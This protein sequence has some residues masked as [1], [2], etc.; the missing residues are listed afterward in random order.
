MGKQP[1]RRRWMAPI[2]VLALL[3][4]AVFAGFYLLDWLIERPGRNPAALYGD[5]QPETISDATGGM[6]GMM[7]AVLGIVI[8]VVSIIVQLSAERY[9]GVAQMFMR[10]RINISVMAYFVIACVCGV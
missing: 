4:L 5:F 7:A 9:T 3:S 10:D 1:A 8:T 2:I 6:A